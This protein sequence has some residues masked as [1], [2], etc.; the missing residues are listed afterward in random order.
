[1]A[2]KSE[3]SW[4]RAGRGWYATIDGRTFCLVKTADKKDKAAREEA[5]KLFHR[6]MVKAA[7]KPQQPTQ[8]PASGFA[9]APIGDCL[10]AK[11]EAAKRSHGET[12]QYYKVLKVLFQELLDYLRGHYGALRIK[13][14]RPFHILAFFDSRPKWNETTRA[15]RTR[16]IKSAFNAWVRDGH[17]EESPLRK[18][19]SG[20]IGSRSQAV[21]LQPEQRKLIED[22]ITDEYFRDFWR[23]CGETG[24]RPGE[25]AGVRA[26]QFNPTSKTWTIPHK[27]KK[28]TGKDKVV[29]LSDSMVELCRKLAASNPTGPMFRNARGEEWTRNAWGLRVAVIRKKTGITSVIAYSNRHTFVTDALMKYPVAVVAA[30]TSQSPQIIH[31]HYAHVEARRAELTEYVNDI[32]SGKPAQ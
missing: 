21:Y 6:A 19:P 31:N 9:E 14:L 32:V 16:Q 29:L 25:V 2:R 5:D 24:C 4:W 11:L 26:D 13:E 23:A 27:T 17:L 8:E 28:L 1:M 20:K 30:I 3:G 7:E 15:F 12:S 10:G 18:L 22:A